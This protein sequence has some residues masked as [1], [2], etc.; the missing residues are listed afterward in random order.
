MVEAVAIIVAAIVAAVGS[1]VV[2]LIQ[3]MR[4][5]NKTDHGMVRQMLEN[6]DE[7]IKIVGEKL[8]DH[9]VWHLNNH[10]D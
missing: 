7:D 1:I 5:E 10:E 8:D 6:L 3:A 4:K 9:I 2:A